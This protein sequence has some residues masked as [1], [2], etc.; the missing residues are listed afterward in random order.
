MSPVGE[1]VRTHEARTGE[2]LPRPA[3]IPNLK[4]AKRRGAGCREV[5]V[6]LAVRFPG[7]IV[8]HGRPC[9]IDSGA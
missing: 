5:A 7:W 8:D 2:A 1:G 4:V 3:S 6:R 9:R